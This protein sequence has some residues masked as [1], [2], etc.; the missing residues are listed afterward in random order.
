MY[1]CCIPFLS[2]PICDAVPVGSAGS[3]VSYPYAKFGINQ[4]RDL[5][6]QRMANC[7]SVANAISQIFVLA[8]DNIVGL[9]VVSYTCAT[10]HSS[11]LTLSSLFSSPFSCIC[12]STIRHFKSRCTPTQSNLV[13]ACSIRIAQTVQHRSLLVVNFRPASLVQMNGTT[14]CEKR[15]TQESLFFTVHG[16]HYPHQAP[17][18]ALSMPPGPDLCSPLRCIRIKSLYGINK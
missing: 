16:F 17:T 11:Q 8:A 6:R 9:D 14:L 7:N 10:L 15:M 13:T 12:V 1:L 4:F 5:Y 2:K 3:T 18:R